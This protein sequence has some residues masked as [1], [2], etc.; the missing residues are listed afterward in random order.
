MSR[1]SIGT[2][3]HSIPL[4]LVLGH[5]SVGTV[6]EVGDR[7]RVYAPGQRVLRPGA[8]YDYGKMGIASAWGGLAE[9]GLVTDLAA[10][11]ADHP[12]EK[13]GG[14]WAK[15]QIVP[16]EIDPV[17]ATAIITLKETLSSIRR[18]ERRSGFVGGHRGYRTRGASVH[19]LGAL[20]RG[21]LS[22]GLRPARTVVR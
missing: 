7:V 12:G 16:R 11:Q 20:V 4:P 18:A 14:M 13:P 15:Q 17:E 1:S 3:F 10:W 8:E 2:L 5:E 21:A 19:L 22:G 6:V 9:Y